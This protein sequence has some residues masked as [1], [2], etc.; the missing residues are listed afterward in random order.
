MSPVRG[1]GQK[2][3]SKFFLKGENGTHDKNMKIETKHI[4]KS[5]TN[6]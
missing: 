6:F 3:L 5:K 2:K 4:I 1:S